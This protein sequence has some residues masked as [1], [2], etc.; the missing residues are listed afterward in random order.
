MSVPREIKGGGPQGATLGL[1]EYLSQS[2]NNVDFVDLKDKYKFIDDLSLL[3]TRST[4]GS[5]Y[6]LRPYLIQRGGGDLWLY[7]VE[8]MLD[9]IVHM[10]S[11]VLFYV[12]FLIKFSID[13]HKH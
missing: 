5:H 8:T 7:L 9:V 3:E 11:I 1:I 12:W 10:L 2:N 4:K 6:K 13:F